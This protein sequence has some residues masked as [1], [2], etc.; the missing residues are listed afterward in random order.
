MRGGNPPAHSFADAT[1]SQDEA[2]SKTALDHH[3]K[4]LFDFTWA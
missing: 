2:F 3:Q 1:L 4:N